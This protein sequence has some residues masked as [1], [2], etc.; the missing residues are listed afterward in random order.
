MERIFGICQNCKTKKILAPLDCSH[1]ICMLCVSSLYARMITEL[2]SELCS[3]AKGY[4]GWIAKLGCPYRCQTVFKISLK[5]LKHLIK[6]NPKVSDNEK[7]IINNFCKAPCF[8]EIQTWF[9]FCSFC[10]RLG[11][12]NYSDYHC[13]TCS[14]CTLCLKSHRGMPCN[15]INSTVGSSE[16]EPT[17]YPQAISR[18]TIN[19]TMPNCI[20]SIEINQT[21]A[22]IANDSP[23]KINQYTLIKSTSSNQLAPIAEAIKREP[24]KKSTYAANSDTSPRKNI[25]N[26]I[27]DVIGHDRYGN[28]YE[29]SDF[30]VCVKIDEENRFNNNKLKYKDRFCEKLICLSSLRKVKNCIVL[31]KGFKRIGT[32]IC[33]VMLPIDNTIA[34]F[35]NNWAETEDAVI[36]PSSDF[37]LIKYS[38]T[39]SKHH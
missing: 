32:M 18:R 5:D 27:R 33:S 39:T 23:I 4:D 1:Q 26:I 36:L 7:L 9:Y 15:A 31:E 6:C 17:T 8:Q 25:F 35:Q 24:I 16:I 29:I 10:S 14:M 11:W 38:V 13:E 34:G 19:N 28:N 2:W 30:D 22:D 21:W 20:N 37:F 12:Y 3:G